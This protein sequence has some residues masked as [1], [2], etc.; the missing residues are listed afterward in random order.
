MRIRAL[1]PVAVVAMLV[2]SL[3][4][5]AASAASSS[6][7]TEPGNGSS[8]ALP[9]AVDWEVHIT[10]P[11]NVVAD[12]TTTYT[13]VVSVHDIAGKGGTGTVSLQ[14]LANVSVVSSTPSAGLT[15]CLPTPA[16]LFGCL[17]KLNGSHPETLSMRVT[18]AGLNLPLGAFTAETLPV[19]ID[20]NPLNNIDVFSISIH[21]P[22][23]P[24]PTPTPTP[25]PSS[26]TP[27]PTPEPSPTPSGTTPVGGVQTGEGGAA[28]RPFPSVPASFA[29]GAALVAALAYTVRRRRRA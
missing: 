3:G 28:P 16:L 27:P 14:T 23:S 4:A 6:G 11:S 21:K 19:G 17:A 12:G 24:S 1:A 29:G 22:S 20:S 26:T 25:S 8:A 13:Y 15:H 10:G 5:S 18:F 7:T 9:G 2:I